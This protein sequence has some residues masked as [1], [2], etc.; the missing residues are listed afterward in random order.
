MTDKLMAK[1]SD[2]CFACGPENPIGFKLK[3]SYDNNSAEAFFTP[4]PEHQGWMDIFHGGLIATLLDE[5]MAHAIYSF[6]QPNCVTIMMNVKYRNMIKIGEK[7]RVVGTLTDISG[8][9]VSAQGFVY[10]EDG[11]V[12][13]EAEAKFIRLKD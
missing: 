6:G 11:S 9:F 12:A 8:R 7:L 10:K 1:S 4:S 5:A 3:F 2:M 13:A